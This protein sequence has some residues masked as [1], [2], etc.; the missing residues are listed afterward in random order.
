M[1]RLKNLNELKMM[2]VTVIDQEPTPSMAQTS[3]QWH[4]G[5]AGIM[6]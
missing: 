3:Y 6:R 2:E 4:E 1:K 5:K